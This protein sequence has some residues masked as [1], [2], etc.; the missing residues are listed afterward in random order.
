MNQPLTNEEK[1]R[2]LE[3]Y[4]TIF[5][6]SE[7]FDEGAFAM[8]YTL[9]ADDLRAYGLSLGGDDDTCKDVIHDLFY[10][11]YIKRKGLQGCENIWNYL[12]R[13]FRNRLLNA[14]RKSGRFLNMEPGDQPFS[15]EVSVLDTLIDEEERRRLKL[16]V[17]EL[18]AELTPR[19]R[20]AVYLRYMQGLDYGEIAKLLDMNVESVRKLV[21]RAMVNLRHKSKMTSPLA[22]LLILLLWGLHH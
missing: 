22:S 11:L 3:D 16:M 4:W 14:R 5:V 12:F 7:D 21:H 15:V 9:T 8:V 10:H 6:N 20:E 1:H 2:R 18:L 17:E 13:A 19:Q